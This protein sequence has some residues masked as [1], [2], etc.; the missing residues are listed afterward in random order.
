MLLLAMYEH[1]IKLL[2]FAYGVYVVSKHM[3]L[4][5]L[6]DLLKMRQ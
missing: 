5:V 4:L 6:E 1:H 3:S 2:I